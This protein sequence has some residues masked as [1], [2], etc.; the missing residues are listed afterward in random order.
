MKK[1]SK[2]LLAPLIGLLLIGASIGVSAKLDTSDYSNCF[3]GYKQVWWFKIP[4]L[5]CFDESGELW[6]T[7]TVQLGIPGYLGFLFG[8]ISFERTSGSIEI[9]SWL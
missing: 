5:C 3:Y 1:M 7:K 2:V 6:C 4:T 9:T 8:T